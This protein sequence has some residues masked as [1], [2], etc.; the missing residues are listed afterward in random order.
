MTVSNADN[1]KITAPT[2]I[3]L[4]LNNNTKGRKKNSALK[5]T[6]KEK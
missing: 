6:R 5:S 1:D 3:F 4:Y 2:F